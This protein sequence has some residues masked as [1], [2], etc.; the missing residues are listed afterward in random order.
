MIAVV[1]GLATGCGEQGDDYCAEVAE[2]QRALTEIAASDDPGAL[3]RALDHYRQLQAE[4]PPDISAQWSQVVGRLEA[5]RDALSAAGVDPASY[6]P[7][8][9]PEGVTREQRTAIRGAARDLG[10]SATRE[11]MEGLE[12]QALDVCRTPLSR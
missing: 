11:A 9:P 8:D 2:H 1:V 4:A 10:S 7:E 12:Q 3:F 5:L 6:D